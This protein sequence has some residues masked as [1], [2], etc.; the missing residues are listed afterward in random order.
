MPA[1]FAW[2]LALRYLVTRWVNL[3][4]IVGVALAVWA[5]IVVIGIFSGFIGAIREDVRRATPDLLVTD[6]PHQQS[7]SALQQ[8]LRDDAVAAAAPRLRHVGVFY[9]TSGMSP[10]VRSQNLDFNNVE[11]SFVMLV[12]IDPAL[13]PQVTGL[14]GWLDRVPDVMRAPDP[15]QPLAV[16]A[17]AEYRGR[18]RAGLPAPRQVEDYRAIWPGLLLGKSRAN[19][20]LS[21]GLQ[22]GDP[23]DVVSAAF[24]AKGGDTVTALQKRFVF[25]GAFDTGHDLHDEVMALVPIEALRTMLGHDAEDDGSVDI[26]TDVAVRLRDGADLNAVAAQLQQ[27]LQAGLGTTAR[28]VSVLTWEQQNQVFLDAVEHERALMKLVLFAVM[29]VS[30]FLIYATLHMMVSQKVKD[31]GILSA[32]GGSPQAV[33]SVFVLCGL[34]VGVTG[35]SLGTGIGILS[36]IWLNPVNDWMHANLGFELFPRQLY[37]L[38]VIPCQLEAEW[39]TQVAIGAVLLSLLVA[40]LPAR[41]AA[42]MP[43]VEALGYE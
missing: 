14:T 37:D 10:V 3:L 17:E 18:K 24:G 28:P 23:M 12:G 2:F 34:V 6:L 32:L 35:A 1:V 4:G 9:L 41:K 11:N 20:Q 43:P 27:R 26:V 36:A 30:A 19:R 38:P 40:W 22:P 29:V 15:D 21:L 25:A 31:L 33:G 5:L 42:R 7:W 8:L 16:P 39:I 13:E